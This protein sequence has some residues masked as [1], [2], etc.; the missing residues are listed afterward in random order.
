[1]RGGDMVLGNGSDAESLEF[2]FNYNP[3]VDATA[4]ERVLKE[5][6]EILDQSG[7]GGVGQPVHVSHV[8]LHRINLQ[9][10]GRLLGQ[11]D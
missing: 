11:F 2:T 6:K 3:P 10:A 5:V 9:P 7:I 4:A 1:M 8:L